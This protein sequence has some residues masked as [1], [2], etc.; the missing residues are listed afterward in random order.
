[1]SAPAL[2]QDPAAADSSESGE[3]VTPNSHEL[4]EIIVSATRRASSLQ[5]TP[6]AVSAVNRELIESAAPQDLGDLAKF[7]P[8]FS[9]AEIPGYNAASFAMRGTG[10]TNIIVYFEAPVA[11]LVDDFVVPSIQTQLLDTFDIEQ[12]EVLRGPQ[13]TLFGKNTTGGAVTVR[14]K[15]PEL[16]QFGGEAQVRYGSFDTIDLNGAFNVPLLGDTLALRL[17]ASYAKSDGHMR[18]GFSYGPI[19]GFGPNP[20]NGLEGEGDG[21]RV[22]GKDV[23]NGRAKLLWEPNDDLSALLQYEV[24]RDRSEG[25]ASVHNTPLGST[26]LFARLGLSQEIDGDPLD[27]GGVSDRD[28]YLVDADDGHRINVD[29][30]YLNVDYRTGAGTISS[31]TGYRDQYS[32]LANS[33]N[34]VSP[35]SAGG[36]ILSLFDLNRT[37][38]HKTFQQEVR[39]A[40]ELDGPLNFVTGAFYARDTIR[41]CVAQLLGFQDLAGGSTP[42]GPWNENPFVLCNRQKG[43][44]KALFAEANWDL[45][46]RLHLTAGGRYTWEKKDWQGRQQIFV[47]N[48]LGTPDPTFTWRDI[49][50]LLDMAD[51]EQYPA[52]VVEAQRKWSEPTWRVSL[53]YDI[54]PDIFTYASYS[55][56]FK[57]GG[58]NDQIGTFAPFGT[59]LDA[60]AAAAQP[61][62]PEIA[63][64]FE[65]GLKSQFLDNRVRFN[66]TGFYVDYTDV[67]K[68][69]NVPLDV[70]GQQFQVTRF[71]NAAKMTVKGIEAELTGRLAPGLTLSGVLGYQDGSYDTYEAPLQ[72]GYDLATA[73]LERT[74]KWQW[75]A[76]ANYET[77][78]AQAALVTANA[79][80][81]YTGRNLY[82]LSVVSPDR[83]T[84]L[85]ARTVVNATLTLSDLDKNRY[86]R[87]IGRNL[88]D[89]RYLVASQIVGNLWTTDRYAAPRS[90]SVEFG[91]RF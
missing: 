31:I 17:V 73:P 78:V 84:Y 13:G 89:K 69:L 15:R 77:E 53:G 26:F 75:T 50:N 60:F 4:S 63:D 91:A 90:W 52:G 56:G 9:A 18:N 44:V 54:T 47:Q 67:Q 32:R 72:T 7:T 10:Q 2:A 38:R 39:Y 5:D 51:F 34:S 33:A 27:F 37:D 82:N 65:L 88:T 81:S 35:M 58:F 66:L 71:V 49:D 8:N 28:G 6:V 12:I 46:D 59:N 83:N 41:F 21:R 16:G 36:Q 23:L 85:D 1:M 68:Q 62:D 70:N 43:D 48:L 45:T 57:S 80:V 74:P 3:S 19:T 30:Y 25:P 29:G 55:R 87:L 40:S 24:L 42:F 64:S 20:W 79:S 22:G 86:V 11:V 61:T 76:N 14:T